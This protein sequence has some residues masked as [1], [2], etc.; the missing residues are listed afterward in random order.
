[1][2]LI[3]FIMVLILWV[4]GLYDGG[5]RLLHANENIFRDQYWPSCL[6]PPAVTLSG[7]EMSIAG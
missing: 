2:K 6:A 4:D 7:V 3:F 1:M 5:K